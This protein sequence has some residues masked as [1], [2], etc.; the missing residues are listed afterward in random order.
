VPSDQR[1]TG[2]YRCR[3]DDLTQDG[4]LRFGPIVAS[5]GAA[6]WWPLLSRHPLSAALQADGVRPIFTRLEI[7]ASSAR[8]DLSSS[9]IAHGRYE[10]AHDRAPDGSVARIFLN[11]WTDIVSTDADT[12]FGKLFAEHVLTRPFAPPEA[13]RVIEVPGVELPLARYRQGRL[14][15]LL[16]APPGAAWLDASLCHD[17]ALAAFGITH[18][19]INQHVNSLVFPRLFEDAAL[20]RFAALGK[21]TTILARSLE[22]AFR[23]PFFAGTAA[24][25]ALR[26]FEVKGK[27]GAVG[28]FLDAGEA[29]R[30]PAQAKPHAY[31]RMGF[32][33]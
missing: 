11:M 10:L 26:A 12:S 23:K 28:V 7:E 13:R 3:F 1:A 27:V 15:E 25:I 21:T 4:R 30:Y 19:D 20:R 6:L 16:E 31:I 2:T 17:A 14:D 32:E 33:P 24:R 22:I 8:L 9:L 5:L 18:T 29:D